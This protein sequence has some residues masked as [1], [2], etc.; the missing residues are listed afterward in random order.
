MKLAGESRGWVGEKFKE[1][2]IGGGFGQNTLCTCMK[3]SNNK[4]KFFLME[5]NLKHEVLRSVQQMAKSLGNRTHRSHLP[6]VSSR[7][8]GSL[9]N[10]IEKSPHK[11]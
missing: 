5:K 11:I 7:S 8:D 9:K 3:L 2:V 1:E 4:K 10:Y 6:S